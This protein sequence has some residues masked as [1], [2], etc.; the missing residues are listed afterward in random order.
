MITPGN[1]C[2]NCNFKYEL[3]ATNTVIYYY[4][5]QPWFSFGASICPQCQA[6]ARLFFPDLHNDY[7]AFF[8]MGD[9]PFITEDFAPEGLVTA[10]EQVFGLKLIQEHKLTLRMN[11]EIAALRDWLR[12]APDEWIMT[13]FTDPEPPKERPET[14]C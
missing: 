9:F 3:A 6:S 2:D 1:I 12:S 13:M 11:Q 14:W 5:C 7:M 10:Y 4:E 8:I